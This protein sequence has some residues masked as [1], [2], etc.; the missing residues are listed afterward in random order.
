M[1]GQVIPERSRCATQVTNGN[2]I[3]LSDLTHVGCSQGDDRFGATRGGHELDLEAVGWIHV[4]DR[5]EIASHESVRGK[6]PVQYHS[7]E[8]AKTH[9]APPGYAVTKRG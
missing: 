9:H 5:A 6:I 2:N 8:W 3:R 4:N 1:G 7:V